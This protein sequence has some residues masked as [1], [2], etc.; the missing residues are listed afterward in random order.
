MVWG[1]AACVMCQRRYDHEN[2]VNV[3]SYGVDGV[4]GMDMQQCVWEGV[5][6]VF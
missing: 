3:D 2:G 1:V 5:A 6:A 4:A